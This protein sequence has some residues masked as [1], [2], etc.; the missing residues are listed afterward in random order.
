M[1]NTVTK[2]LTC[3]LAVT[4][5]LS[6]VIVPQ[7]VAVAE[8][9]RED[10]LFSKA[11]LSELGIAPD[12]LIF[13]KDYTVY[14]GGNT[15][16][17][18]GWSGDTGALS[19]SSVT[20][21][22]ADTA[23]N[24]LQFYSPGG[25][26]FVNY[27]LPTDNFLLKLDMYTMGENGGNWDVQIL[28]SD[29]D[30]AYSMTIPAYNRTYDDQASKNL[31]SVKNYIGENNTYP[32]ATGY[33]L[34]VQHTNLAMELVC[35][36]GYFYFVNMNGELICR[37]PSRTDVS[38]TYQLQ[39][40]SWAAG[41]VITE[42]S[43]TGLTAAE[44]SFASSIGAK[45]DG[46]AFYADYRGYRTDDSGETTYKTDFSATS[47]TVQISETTP[48]NK[49]SKVT[50]LNL[51]NSGGSAFAEIDFTAADYVAKVSY[52]H[53]Y[54]NGGY[55]SVAIR[56]EAGVYN[57]QISLPFSNRNSDEW[58]SNLLAYKNNI[59][60]RTTAEQGF[61]GTTKYT[62]GTDVMNFCNT[63]ARETRNIE[64][65]IYIYSYKGH[66]Y[67]LTFDQNG[68]Q[69]LLHKNV[70]FAEKGLNRT[71]RLHADW[72]GIVVKSVHVQT[73]S[74]DNSVENLFADTLGAETGKTLVYKD[75][76]VN[77]AEKGSWTEGKIDTAAPVG[78]TAMETYKQQDKAEPS[79]Y[80][81]N[82]GG[83]SASYY[84]LTAD[85]FVAKV[86]FLEERGRDAFVCIG[87]ADS[88]KGN[89]SYVRFPGSGRKTEVG[90]NQVHF[91]TREWLT[92]D[93]NLYD[94]SVKGKPFTFYIFCLG[95][96]VY[97]TDPNGKLIYNESFTAESG[98]KLL[99]AGDWTGIDL[100]NLQ[101]KELSSVY[102]GGNG[103]DAAPFVIENAD[104]LYRAVGSF[105]GGKHYV[106]GSD[107]YL[108][109]ADAINWNNGS[110]I[111]EGYEPREWFHNAGGNTS[112]YVGSD[113]V[114]TGTFKGTLDGNGYA[115]HGI[116]YPSDSVYGVVGL[117]PDT[118]ETTVKNLVLS[119]SFVRGYPKIGSISSRSLN[120]VFENVLIDETVTVQHTGIWTNS[121]SA[122]AFV[123]MSETGGRLTFKN[124]ATYATVDNYGDGRNC[125][126]V[127]STWT[128]TVIE[129]ENCI[130]I[131]TIPF[132]GDSNGGTQT[133]AKVA[134]RFIHTNVYSDVE[135]NCSIGCTDGTYTG[136]VFG[137]L[138]S[139]DS[140]KG[141]NAANNMP[142]LFGENT[143]WYA[144]TSDKY[145]QLRAW[146]AAHNDIDKSGMA[147]DAGDFAA[148]RLIIIGSKSTADYEWTDIDK[149]ADVDICDLVLLSK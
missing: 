11:L 54:H 66:V 129:A 26:A 109:D 28:N 126:L 93:K 38:K 146:G 108:N 13:K 88:E 53:S 78:S 3:I 145:P 30:L 119:H 127:G 122:G 111:K 97:W 16:A 113:G 33:T 130:C 52:V 89:L 49:T 104:Q 37:M 99:I 100:L 81:Q 139:A 137:T 95:N 29:G 106:L 24:G 102:A 10:T 64:A 116:W 115:I 6:C 9:V 32:S 121:F 21:A 134:E 2:L 40:R 70:A 72:G 149:N 63:D 59:N 50:G 92:L 15:S 17:M 55:S 117:L 86:T 79:L 5:L 120:G 42:M 69:V 84:D 47:G 123:G 105:G 43:L 76:T 103:S 131:G 112:F 80:V 44:D 143:V 41:A 7:S 68:K 101:V 60:L 75:Y 58:H 142:E 138:A 133:M 74:P 141:A 4:L 61:G 128:Y 110:V 71:L 147:K 8:S 87:V 34:S 23:V 67:Y 62:V 77:G 19:V 140:A 91:K 56:D 12:E 148:L 25:N 31:F 45:V 98:R 144:S 114:T 46:T 20:P 35:Y 73:L 22:G 57:A 14:E 90:Y 124:C 1:K 36:N 85:N 83:F 48:Y 27:Q 39:L 107:I 65:T 82:D 125:G 118:N 18:E 94:L 135:Y 132:C 51:S 136:I 96:T